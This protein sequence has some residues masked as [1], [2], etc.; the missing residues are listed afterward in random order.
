MENFAFGAISGIC[1][2]VISH[3]FDTIK[4]HIQRNQKIHYDLRSLYKGISAPILGIGIE[5]AVVFGSYSN[6][7]AYGNNIS[8]NEN[9]KTFIYGC[10]AGFNASFVVTPYE[11]IKILLQTGQGGVSYA[12]MVNPLSLWKGLLITFTREIPGFGIYFANYEYWKRKLYLEKGQNITKLGAFLLG[13]S[14]GL[15]AWIFIYPQDRIKTHVQSM[16]STNN[17]SYSEALAH[18]RGMKLSKL[19]KG[20]EFALMRS[21]PLHAGTFCTMELLT[22]M[23]NKQL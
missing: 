19:Y 9:L 2:L 16:I 21:I 6:L 7:K 22:S 18:L 12:Q 17:Q 14:S 11:R 23:A 4:T 10:I 1:G 8:L 13:G 15:L 20:I 5:K 3:P